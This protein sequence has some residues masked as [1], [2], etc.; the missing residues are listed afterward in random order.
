MSSLEFQVSCHELVLAWLLGCRKAGPGSSV[1]WEIRRLPLS[2]EEAVA[3][4][5][6]N[7]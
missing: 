1:N 7:C 6:K 3:L 4:S 2:E 5:D